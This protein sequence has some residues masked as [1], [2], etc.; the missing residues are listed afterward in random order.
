MLY[1]GLVTV[2]FFL[3]YALARQGRLGGLVRL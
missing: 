2:L 3:R 1:V